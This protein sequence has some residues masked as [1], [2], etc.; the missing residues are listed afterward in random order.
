MEDGDLGEAVGR[1][2]TRRY[3]GEDSKA[4]TNA[5][6]ESLQKSFEANLAGLSWMDDAT[7]AAALAKVQRMVGNNKIGYPNVWRDYSTL[8]TT[9]SS[10]FANS[11]AANRF[12]TKRS[13]AKI[14]KPVDRNEWGMSPPTVNAYYSP[15]KNEIVFPAGILQPPFFNKE[16]TDAVN[17][18]SMGMV[19]GHEI[20]HGFDDQGRQFDVDGNLKDWWSDKV[21]KDFVGRAECVKKQYDNYVAVKD[22]HLNGALTLG[23][24]IADLGGIKMA[25]GAMTDWYS[26]KGGDDGYRYDRPQQFFL[27]MAQA[28]CTKYREENALLRVKTDPHSPPNWRVNGPM[29]NLD[30][31]SKAFQCTEQSKMVRKGAERCVVW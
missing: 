31:F 7:R 19:V 18:G 2:F 24:N 4:R 30:A 10:F 5:I 6:V 21:G 27:G 17:F 14:G 13:L 15:Q 20:T 3:F 1:E 12:E 16:A 9:K 25:Y 11:I 23:E 26:K 28:W 22:V 8:Q 29:G